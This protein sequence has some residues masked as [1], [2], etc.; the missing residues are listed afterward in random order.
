MAPTCGPYL[1]R[2]WHICR[3]LLVIDFTALY[4]LQHYLADYHLIS[5]DK[6]LLKISSIVYI[7]ISTMSYLILVAIRLV[8]QI[9]T[10]IY[11]PVAL[12]EFVRM[13]HPSTIFRIGCPADKKFTNA[14]GPLKSSRSQGPRVQ[15][16]AFCSEV[17]IY[18]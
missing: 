3:S 6:D 7:D 11:L 4:H 10:Y 15:L 9:L 2:T 14:P 5:S 1:V 13:I 8:I 18:R 17:E 16:M 12:W